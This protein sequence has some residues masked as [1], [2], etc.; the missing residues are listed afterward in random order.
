MILGRKQSVSKLMKLIRGRK[1]QGSHIHS[2]KVGAVAAS[3]SHCPEQTGARYT[4]LHINQ[5]LETKVN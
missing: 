4:H 1:K 3:H 5:A 2:E